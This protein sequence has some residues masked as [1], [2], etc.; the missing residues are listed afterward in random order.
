M[1]IR[2]RA[3]LRLGLGGGGTDLSPFCDTFGGQVLNATVDLH[4]YAHIEATED[5]RVVFDAR[6]LQT[7]ETYPAAPPLP[8]EGRLAL[9]QAVHNRVVRQFRD[10][11]PLSLRLTTHCDAPPG[12]GL[13]SSSTLVVAILA[14]YAEWLALGLDGHAL[15]RLAWEIERQELG[16]SGGRQDQYAAAFGGFNFMEFRTDDRVV[17][18]RLRPC[19][20]IVSE[21]EAS[22]VLFYTGASR[23][24]AAIIDQQTRNVA[25]RDNAAID[26][27]HAMKA[28]AADMRDALIAGD[29]AAIAALL[30]KGWDAKQ[31]TADCISNPRIEQAFALAIGAGARAGKVS[32]AGGGGFIMFMVDPPRRPDVV[33]ALARTDGQVM[34]CHFVERGVE[35]WRAA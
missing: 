14:A 8:A 2:A 26:A 5:G 20:W 15:A 1:R 6:D 31:R 17:V 30:A 12:S 34:A 33:R 35:T 11:A 22:L 4:A 18:N 7:C 24:S 3:P 23:A 25:A 21:L 19:G 27:M 32:G 28:D 9:H 10:G 13:G 29:F 16:L